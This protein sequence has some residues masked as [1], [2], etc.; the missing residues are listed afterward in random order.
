M[1]TKKCHLCRRTAQ[2]DEFELTCEQC[3]PKELDLLIGTFWFMHC[4]G[5]DFC[6]IRTIYVD[7]DPVGGLKVSPE[8]MRSWIN[9]GYL[10]MNELKCVRVPPPVTN[11]LEKAGYN[12]TPDLNRTLDEV[13][14]KHR[15][16]VRRGSA[17][18]IVTDTVQAPKRRMVYQEKGYG[19]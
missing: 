7:M 11:Y 5:S 9:R 15:E 14:I 8:F 12:Q 10:E 4:Y 13:E 6:P 3:T 2:I 17:D 18:R 1:P 19:R 16:K